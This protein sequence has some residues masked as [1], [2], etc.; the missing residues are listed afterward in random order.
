MKAA[1]ISLGLL[2]AFTPWYAR[3]DSSAEV[4]Y[5]VFSAAFSASISYCH[6]K[7]GIVA[8][9]SRGGACFLRAKNALKEFDLN[10][11]A[12]RISQSCVDSSKLETCITPELSGVVNS[13]L[14][15]FDS[16]KL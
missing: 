6:A 8:K 15:L 4:K 9:S 10:G 5:A 14:Q 7:H 12:T 11:A 2:L 1:S 3:A 13:L 16:K